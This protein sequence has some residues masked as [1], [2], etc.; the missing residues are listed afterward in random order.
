MGMTC[1]LHRVSDQRLQDLIEA[2]DTVPAFLYP[3]DETAPPMVEVRPR[4]LL[5]LILRLLGIKVSE[6]A[7][8]TSIDETAFTPED[9]EHVLELDKAWH[10][11]HFLLTGTAEDGAGPAAFLVSGG[12]PLD[13]EGAARGLTSSEVRQIA[14]SL[15]RVSP[16]IAQERY[17]PF[18]MTKLDV[19]PRQIW[20][21]PAIGDQP[22]VDWLIAYYHELLRFIAVAAEA[23]DAVIVR[24]S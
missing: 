13:E 19:Y 24:V 7:A 10:G 12:Q 8:S 5:G 16:E 20:M 23:G 21:R 9:H 1:T 4:G 14:E 15:A 2:P 11:L 17:D 18:R 3:E 22:P 6:V